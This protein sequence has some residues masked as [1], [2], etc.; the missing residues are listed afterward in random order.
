MNSYR[1]RENS[2]LIWHGRLRSVLVA[3]GAFCAFCVLLCPPAFAQSGA[4]LGVVSDTSGAVIPNASVTISNTATGVTTTTKTD[5]QGLYVF[6]YVQPGVYDVS[7]TAAGFQTVKKPGVTVNVTERVQ[8][9]FN[10]KIGDVKQTVTVLNYK[11][12]KITEQNIKDVV[13]P[14]WAWRI[15]KLCPFVWFV[16]GEGQEDPRRINT[17]PQNGTNCIQ[18]VFRGD[19]S[20]VWRYSTKQ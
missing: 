14:K 10:L 3:L 20:H 18:M 12:A 7:A 11:G 1:D 4:V 9:S 16:D 19:T 5:I 15:G 2:H 13:G 17:G 8:V 6:P